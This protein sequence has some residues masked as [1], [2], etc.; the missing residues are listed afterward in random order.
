MNRL[1]TFA[2]VALA[3]GLLATTGP[4]ALAGDSSHHAG[5]CSFTSINGSEVEP[6][7]YRGEIHGNF[8]VY[9]DTHGNV[10]NATVT[11]EVRV[12]GVPTASVTGS[13]TT[14]VAVA[15]TL[16]YTADVTDWVYL[17]T[18][19][20][21]TSDSTPSE[22][23]CDDVAVDYCLTCGGD[24]DLVAYVVSTVSWASA[25]YLDPQV[26]PVLQSLA[27]GVG[28][29][30]ITPEG[31]AYYPTGDLFWDC[32]P[33]ETPVGPPPGD[34]QLPFGIP[35]HGPTGAG[36][37]DGDTGMLALLT[38]ATTDP[39]AAGTANVAA[40]CAFRTGADGIAVTGATTAP[41]AD[42]STVHCTLKDA[43]SGAVLYDDT[44]TASGP[45]AVLTGTAAGTGP[46]T[47]CTEGTATWG[48]TTA[49][50]GAYCR[51][52]LPI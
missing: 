13:G 9:S 3:A 30:V 7:H 41:G 15:G 45:A 24:T 40:F 31:D 47:V 27:P 37:D 26:C 48:T 38:S 16:E 19:V 20:D 21:Y 1:R 46:V 42:S 11:C 6:D 33:Y 2:A 8:V 52:G 14:L 29:I 44:V 49:T 34:P 18:T 12:S 10:V 39:G 23:W 22:S 51:P 35:S 4:A 5:H 25:V 36:Y 17:C 32:P 43:G 28:P 50:T